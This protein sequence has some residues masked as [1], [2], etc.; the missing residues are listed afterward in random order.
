MNKVSIGG[1]IIKTIIFSHQC[2]SVTISGGKKMLDCSGDERGSR[3]C[4]N[5]SWFRHVD[6][7]SHL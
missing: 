5:D 7:G 4:R 2:E 3:G 1:K 6:S